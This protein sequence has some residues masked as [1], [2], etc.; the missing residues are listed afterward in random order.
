MSKV[1]YSSKLMVTLKRGLAGK[2]YE[3]RDVVA[4]LGLK[5]REQTVEKNNNSTIRGMINKVKR[6]L[7]VETRE[8]YDARMAEEARRK[9]PRPPIVVRHSF[10]VKDGDASA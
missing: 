10:P 2:R 9:A 6:L 4:S 8:M 3:H 5:R 1:E 7:E